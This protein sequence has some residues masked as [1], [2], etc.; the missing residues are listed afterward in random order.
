MY[1]IKR[2]TTALA[3]RFGI[4]IFLRSVSLCFLFCKESLCTLLS[5]SRMPSSHQFSS[6]MMTA[7]VPQ[8]CLTHITSPLTLILIPIPSLIFGLI[9]LNA[10]NRDDSNESNF[11]SHFGA[12]TMVLISA[13]FGPAQSVMLAFPFER[14]MFLREYATGTCKYSIVQYVSLLFIA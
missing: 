2:D 1:N 9:F 3:A 14:P 10:G 11:Y 13:M 8:Q 4:T 5:A 6:D 7:G 12:V